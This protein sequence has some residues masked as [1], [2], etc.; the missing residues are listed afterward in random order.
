ML[1]PY[2]A[3]VAFARRHDD[4]ISRRH[5]RQLG[6]SDQA[7]SLRRTQH[8]WSSPVRGALLV[9]PVGD[10][11]RAHAR[12]A[13]EVTGEIVCALTAARLHGLPGLPRHRPGELVD[14][15]V[16]GAPGRRQRRGCRR[17]WWD[18]SRGDV[19]DLDGIRAT[20]VLRTLEDLVLTLDRDAMVCVLDAM[21]NTRLLSLDDLADIRNRLTVRRGAEAIGR[22]WDLVDGRA[23]SPLESR[24]RLL[25]TDGGVPPEE[26]Q[27]LVRNPKTGRAVARLDL[28]WPSRRV[29]VEADGEQPHSQPD[30]LFRDRDRQNNL[31]QLRW[32]LLR[33]TWR[34]VLH[35]GDH[36]VRTVRTSLA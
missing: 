16:V 18:V 35:R 28:A 22:L 32:E 9:P 12:A 19:V 14:L 5:A 17:H 27:C 33:F 23:E 1:E 3:V 36:V 21:L 15:A 26:L 10:E 7:I 6:M 11:V 29:A 34:D 4:V 20:S 25:L 31:V 13:A 8:G 24:L 2:D 30:P